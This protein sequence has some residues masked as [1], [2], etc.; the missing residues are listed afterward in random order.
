LVCG[1]L[2]LAPAVGGTVLCF[3]FKASPLAAAGAFPLA[4]VFFRSP[5]GL[6]SRILRV[7]ASSCNLPCTAPEMG[8]G[9]FAPLFRNLASSMP[10]SFAWR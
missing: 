10:E 5:F 8:R 9:A 1:I 6:I 3:V 2:I 7:G 4:A